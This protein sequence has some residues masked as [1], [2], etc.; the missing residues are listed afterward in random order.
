MERGTKIAD[1]GDLKTKLA[2]QIRR[3][4]EFE[5]IARGIIYYEDAEDQILTHDVEE[6]ALLLEKADE[7]IHVRF[8]VSLFSCPLK[9]CMDHG[10]KK[11]QQ[12][13]SLSFLF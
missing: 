4:K 7:N 2:E 3:A 9:P 8:I 1:Y 12:C 10:V 11:R 5:A 13:L 6:I